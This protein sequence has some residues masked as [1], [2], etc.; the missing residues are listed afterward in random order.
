MLGDIAEKAGLDPQAALAAIETQAVKDRL[1]A[2][3][4]AAIAKGAFGAPA[5]FVGDELFWGNDRLD[6]VERALRA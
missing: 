5:L 6:F 3:T 2:F 1:R 4:D